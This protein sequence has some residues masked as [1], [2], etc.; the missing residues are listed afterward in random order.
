MG[1]FSVL[2]SW[3]DGRGGSGNTSLSCWASLFGRGASVRRSVVAFV[4][5]IL[6]S[7]ASV[8]VVSPSSVVVAFI[9]VRA[10]SG[11]MAFLAAFEAPPWSI[12]KVASSSWSSSLPVISLG[13]G[14]SEFAFDSLA[15][16]VMA[17]HSK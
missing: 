10:L 3:L 1:A 4:A 14:S 2:A 6:R 7:V 17:S 11:E 15:F 8:V 13:A 9:G 5:V 16:D 12:A